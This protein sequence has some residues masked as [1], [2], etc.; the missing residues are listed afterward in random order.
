M[1][2]YN[3]ALKVFS[4]LYVGLKTQKGY[5]I[6][7]ETREENGQIFQDLK[8]VE[9][10]RTD[11][12]F[13]T[14]YEEGKAAYAKRKKTVDE[15]STDTRFHFSKEPKPEPRFLMLDNV[16]RGGFKITDD[17]KRS[18]WGGGNVVFRVYDPAGFE[19]EIQSQNLMMLI[20]TCGIDAGGLI[21]GACIWGRDGAHNVL[22]HETSEEFKNAIMAAEEL[23]KPKDLSAKSKVV[24]STYTMQNGSEVVY[25]GKVFVS[26]A[27]FS[28]DTGPE[29][30]F[31]LDD[32]RVLGVQSDSGSLT[33]A[34]I[35]EAV[36]NETKSVTLYRKASFARLI[37]EDTWTAQQVEKYLV[38]TN[39]VH[40]ATSRD[41]VIV[42]VSTKKPE[43]LIYQ[44]TPVTE[45]EY[46]ERLKDS[47]YPQFAASRILYHSAYFFTLDVWCLRQDNQFYTSLF[48]THVNRAGWHSY[49]PNSERIHGISRFE[50][51]E[52]RYWIYTPSHDSHYISHHVGDT[53]TFLPSP[54][55]T[56]SFDDVTA[57][58]E[59]YFKRGDL[60]KLE[61]MEVTE[62]TQ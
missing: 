62:D 9:Y 17:I 25:L 48:N 16:P 11:L 23:Q 19:L 24:G 50:I 55:E 56:N 39:N 10:E 27:M 46:T 31:K 18:Y 29:K 14:P 57:W 7:T 2:N 60:L 38:N 21:P 52:D 22:V 47:S 26:L 1:S 15:W 3:K 28:R 40:F 59:P 61:V 51:N 43:K 41:G 58:I 20:N 13:A 54:P 44:L 45:V 5:D 37:K 53:N 35:Y 33:E 4:K 34:E 6:V 30:A 32:G 36:L 49:R 8:R 12:G 42:R